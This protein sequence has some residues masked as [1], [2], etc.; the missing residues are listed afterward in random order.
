MLRVMLR[1]AQFPVI[2]LPWLE[3]EISVIL[4]REEEAK[5]NSPIPS[6]SVHVGILHSVY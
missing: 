3:E 1:N 2:W 6:K 4:I 5:R